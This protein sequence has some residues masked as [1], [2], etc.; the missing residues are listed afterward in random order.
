[1]ILK[2]GGGWR[3]DSTGFLSTW[4]KA[5]RS[6]N[7]AISEMPILFFHETHALPRGGKTCVHKKLFRQPICS[8]GCVGGELRGSVR[9]LRIL[10][11]AP[12]RQYCQGLCIKGIRHERLCIYGRL[13]VPD[14]SFPGI[15]NPCT[16][17]EV[18]ERCQ[19][20]WMHLMS[21]S[22]SNLQGVFG[23]RGIWRECEVCAFAVK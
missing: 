23:M 16:R 8:V 9:L 18:R 19:R 12:L 11:E 17:K 7:Q 15:L 21:S 3:I 14:T 20:R 10:S 1:M 4:K 22:S 2:V 6:G 13:C 5:I